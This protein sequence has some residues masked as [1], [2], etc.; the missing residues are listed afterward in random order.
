MNEEQIAQKV[1]QNIPQPKP[2]P[3]SDVPLVRND[4]PTGYIPKLDDTQFNHYLQDYFDL[5]GI[6]NADGSVASVISGRNRVGYSLTNDAVR[7]TPPPPPPSLTG[8]ST[9]TGVQSLTL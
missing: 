4:G 2:E 9:I 3:K 8:I 1:S 5:Q 6:Q 7:F